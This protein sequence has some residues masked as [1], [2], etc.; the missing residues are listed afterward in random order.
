MPGL[1]EADFLY[2][3]TSVLVVDSFWWVASMRRL[4]K[5]FLLC[6]RVTTH[7]GSSR[8]DKC[9]ASA[10]YWTIFSC[11]GAFDSSEAN[12][13]QGMT[14]YA[15]VF[16]LLQYVTLPEICGKK[17]LKSILCPV[18]FKATASFHLFWEY[19]CWYQFGVTTWL[20]CQSSKK[21]VLW[22]T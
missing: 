11:Q 12:R 22:K 3:G 18:F 8:C 19:V 17:I 2:S 21:G 1:I 20:V 15:S 4:V 9:W 6:N 14:L 5:C 7:A 10:K 16:S 13:Y